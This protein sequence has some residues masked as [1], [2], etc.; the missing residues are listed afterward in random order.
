MNIPTQFGSDWLNDF[1]EDLNRHWDNTLLTHLG[2]F[3]SFMYFW[4]TEK[5]KHKY[6]KEPSYEHSYL[7]WFQ[8][9]RWFQ[10]RWLNTFYALWV[11]FF[12]LSTSDHPMII[13]TKIGSNWFQIRLKCKFLQTTWTAMIDTQVMAIPHKTLWIGWI[14]KKLFREPSDE[15]S[16]QV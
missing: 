11:S 5:K 2:L 13:P 4:S 10:K 1:W 7:V 16:Y 3:V 14:K 9:A 8:L 12:L 6:F 15:Y